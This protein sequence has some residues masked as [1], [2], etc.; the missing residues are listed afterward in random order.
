[1]TPA[2]DD[3][4]VIDLE[5]M[6]TQPGP[7]A[8][9]HN[10]ATSLTLPERVLIRHSQ[11][12]PKGSSAVVDKHNLVF[13]HKERDAT[14][15]EIFEASVSLTITCPRNDMFNKADFTRIYGMIDT[16]LRASY[17][18]DTEFGRLAYLL[19]NGT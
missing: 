2:P 12:K 3:P 9:Y 19:R 13:S 18:S 14:S 11:L 7:G 1:M 10:I 5:L 17:G 4:E 15:G 16:F 8:E 6:T